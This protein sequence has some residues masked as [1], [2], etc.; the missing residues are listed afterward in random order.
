MTQTLDHHRLRRAGAPLQ[1]GLLALLVALAWAYVG[2]GFAAL[3]A[4]GGLA[5][6][7]AA[8]CGPSAGRAVTA[9][10]L[11]FSLAMWFAASIAMM[12]PSA[13]GLV[14][15]YAEIAETAAARSVRVVP[16]GVLVAGYLTVWL[17]F[18]AAAA[19]LQAALAASGLIG[20]GLL[21]S[22]RVV[23]GA[24]L[25]GAGA[26]Q[27]SALKEACLS[28]C[29]MPFP[30]LF[31]NWSVSAARIYRL[32]LREGAYCLGCCWA[33]MLTMFALGVMNVL[34]MAALA[35]F[36]IVEKH[37]EKSFVSR[38]G[39]IFLLLAGVYMVLV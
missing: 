25:I 21:L 39:G 27:F 15:T 13:W 33:L 29:R 3:G 22:D 8:I 4:E 34:W 9:G 24:V 18:S 2:M 35:A 14:T 38:A 37:A 28:K 10:S 20:D 30:T 23:A 19:L 36:A 26:F 1:L 32:G 17:G 11:A 6:R 16:V 5:A 12:L 31:A 7:L